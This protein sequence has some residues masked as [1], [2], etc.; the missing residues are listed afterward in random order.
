MR[1]SDFVE[2]LLLTTSTAIGDTGLRIVAALVILLVGW[3]VAVWS[4]RVVRGAAE[5]SDKLDATLTPLFA[6]VMRI[7]VLAVTLVMVLDKLGVDTTSII[8]FM[9]AFGI[10]VGLALKDTIADLAS[11]IVL[12]V[13]RP[14]RVAEAVDIG[15]EMGMVKAVDLF[16]TKLETFDGVPLVMPNSRVRSSVIKNFSRAK[17]RRIDLGI[18]VA[19]EADVVRAIEVV[20]AV[21]RS[22]DR[23]LP[24]PDILVNVEALADSSVDLLVRFWTEPADFLAAKLDLTKAIKLALDEANISIPYPKRD[25]FVRQV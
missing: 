23:V 1:M 22:D 13:L 18:G 8:A 25:V 24:D 14:I 10:A 6:K 17:R 7:A 5:R 16:E 4:S 15:G 11:G 20:S 3:I 9:G 12:L 2:N 19:Y 21:L